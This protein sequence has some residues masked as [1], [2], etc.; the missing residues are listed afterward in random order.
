MNE[1]IK[2]SLLAWGKS[3]A[4]GN[5]VNLGYPRE[6][7]ESRWAREGILP[8]TKHKPLEQTPIQ[9]VLDRVHRTWGAL[10]LVNRNAGRVVQIHYQYADKPIEARWKEAK[11]KKTKYY[12]LLESGHTFFERNF[13]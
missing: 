5:R 9:E 1:F 3:E 10:N 4:F 11:L 13:L 6:C 8:A 2:C 12:L 7:Q